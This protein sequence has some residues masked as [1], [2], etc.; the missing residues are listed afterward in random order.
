GQAGAM[1]MGIARALCLAD[2]RPRKKLREQGLLTRDPRAGGRKKPGGGGAGKGVQVRK[3]ERAWGVGLWVW[4]V[5]R[6][7]RPA[8]QHPNTHVARFD[9]GSLR[10]RVASKMTATADENPRK[11]VHDAASVA[12]AVGSRGPFRASD[13]PVESEDAPVHFRRALRYLHHRSP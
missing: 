10:G 1:R 3:R 5:F 12:G 11:G 6:G 7:S 4:V 2:E 9:A 8:T 13:A